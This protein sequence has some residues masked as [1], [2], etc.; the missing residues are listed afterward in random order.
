MKMIS[1]KMAA[2]LNEQ[3]KNEFFAFWSYLAMAYSFESMG[4][5]GFAQWFFAQADEEKGHATKIAGYLLDQG[6]EVILQPLPEPKAKYASVEEIIKAAQQHELKVTKQVH[7]IVDLA[8]A[9]NDHATRKFIDWKV[10]EQVEEVSTITA[11][12]ELVQKCETPGQL[13]MM[14]SQLSRGEG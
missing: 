6:A 8:V 7:E 14:E 12:L 10:E 9:E 2:R 11:M 4:F 1:D 3:V 13:L 5:K